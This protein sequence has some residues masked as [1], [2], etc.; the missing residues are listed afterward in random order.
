[1]PVFILV[2][3]VLGAGG[4]LLVPRAAYRLTVPAGEPWRAACPQGH[5]FSRGPANGWLG[6]A[7][8]WHQRGRCSYGPAG[9]T[10]P[11]ITALACALL[12]G[13]VGP[14][15]ELV[16]WLMFAPVALVLA[17]VDWE[18]HRLPDALTL[19]TAGAILALLGAASLFPG[20]HG[21][22]TTAALGMLALAGGLLLLFTIN[23]AG[24]GLGDVKLALSIGAALGW[25]G[26]TV[27]LAGTLLAF[28]I[29]ALY[30]ITLLL[31]GRADRWT[32]MPFGPMLLLG[33][34]G[35]LVLGALGGN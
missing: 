4:G 24:M 27:L 20:H 32:A 7:I 17:V 3:A 34:F 11:I 5:A 14:R 9:V 25:Y 28:L 16:V 6:L 23:P 13:V 15:P 26:W 18:V 1:M 8:C 22:L 33:A 35:G 2:A 12:A 29:G 30:G 21:S 19:P 10:A 31:V